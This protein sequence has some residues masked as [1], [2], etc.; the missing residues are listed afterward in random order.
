MFYVYE[1]QFPTYR[2]A[3]IFCG[4]NGIHGEVIYEEEEE[5]AYISKRKAKAF[6]FFAAKDC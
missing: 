2:D 1:L 6:F 4:E 5:E 3:E